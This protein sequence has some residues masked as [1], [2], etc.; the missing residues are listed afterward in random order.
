MTPPPVIALLFPT[1]PIDH[2]VAKTTERLVRQHR[3]AVVYATHV[4]GSGFRYQQRQKKI[5][6]KR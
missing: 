1:F 6:G 5:S 3:S 4:R 2:F